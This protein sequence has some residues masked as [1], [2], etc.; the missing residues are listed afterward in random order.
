[1]AWLLFGS[2]G[3]LLGGLFL[4]CKDLFPYVA[5]RRSGVI[6]RKGARG[7]RIR[8]D[9]D[10]EGFARLL[11]NRSRAVALALGLSL[12]G[13]AVLGLFALSIFGFSGPLALLILALYAGFALFAAFCLIRG[14]TTGRMFAFWGFSFFGE[15][16][17]KQNAI[18]F[19]VYALANLL[20]VLSALS[21][22]LLM[23]R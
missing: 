11:A 19:W 5:A 4:A 17:L 2:I 1:M 13:A 15:A 20:I 3:A 7:Q 6:V 23:V 9:E 8:R 21:T 10:P 14:F 16:T 12:A 18:W 22:L